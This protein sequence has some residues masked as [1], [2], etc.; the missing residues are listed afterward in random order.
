MLETL[1]SLVYLLVVVAAVVIY[2]RERLAS[3]PDPLAQARAAYADGR[4]D[5][6]EYERRVA[7]HVDDRNDRIR[8]VVE[9]VNGVGPATSKAIAREYASLEDLRDSDRERLEGVS[10][11]G[12]Q[13]ADAVLERVR[14]S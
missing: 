5:H 8:A 12:E 11:V 6:A 9:R 14:R 2:A 4:I 1:E 7:F 10:G 13:T 3:D